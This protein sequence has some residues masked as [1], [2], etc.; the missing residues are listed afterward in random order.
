MLEKS[1]GD[2][3]TLPIARAKTW[4]VQADL[5][6]YKS[7]NIAE[8]QDLIHNSNEDNSNAGSLNV[9]NEALGS[10]KEAFAGQG[11]EVLFVR[12]LLY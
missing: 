5:M 1:R 8:I 9:L 4:L 7:K 6:L 2:Q 12:C 11:L 3:Q 10:A